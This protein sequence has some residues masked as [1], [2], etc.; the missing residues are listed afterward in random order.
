MKLQN[1]FVLTGLLGLAGLAAQAQQPLVSH[2]NEK[3]DI[4][5][6][7]LLSLD[8]FHAVDLANYVKF[9]PSSML[10]QLS[11]IGVTY[12]N[13]SSSKPSDSFPGL[14][15][16][17]TGG[18]PVSTG[19]YYDN[20]YD[21]KLLPPIT[22]GLGN[23][24]GTNVL[25]D[26]SID[27]DGTILSGG[28]GIN[29]DA[30]P[31]D[32]HTG[33][34]VY[35]HSFLR[36]NTIFEVAKKAGLHTAWSDKHRAY[37]LVN[38][39]TGAGVDDLYTPEVAANI[40]VVGGK[41]VDAT[42]ALAGIGLLSTTKSVKL[43]EA[44]DDLKVKATLNEIDGK[45]HTG[46]KS[47]GTPALFGMNFQAISVGQKL[48]KEPATPA[49]NDPD[50]L[51][52]QSGG[53]L[54][55]QATPGPLLQ[56]ALDHTDASLGMMVAELGKKG[57]LNST[58]IIVT[59]KHGQSPIDPTKRQAA[60]DGAYD[61]ILNGVEPNLIAQKTTDD[62]ALLW[63][64][65]QAV[66]EDAVDALETNQSA[67]HSQQILSGEALKL[68]F[69]DPLHD[70]RVPDIIVLPDFGVIYTGGSKLAEHGGFNETDTHVALLLSNPQLSR[71][72]LKSPVE[73]TQVAPTI[74]QVLNLDPRAL[75]AVRREAT[76]PL[77][78]PGL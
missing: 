19:V 65:D 2:S 14:L 20:S 6:V 77:P 66:T 37:D 18:T 17:I 5:H 29:P 78:L 72:T 50:P 60:D 46:K 11:G 39:P 33:Q 22:F 13:A 62:V 7:L 1:T 70:S 57:L 59:A 58:L 61:T 44:Y 43:T 71:A 27:K 8:G 56:D 42:D 12:T 53:Y 69:P 76:T 32:P 52:S 21:R 38:G 41:A 31:R 23:Y 35:P 34:P 26:E 55:S 73:T 16:L 75:Q 10:G 51:V 40:G 36:V 15:A 24:P 63:L 4:K 64:R 68:I 67:I 28:G 47:V 74:L 49:G 30:L 9:H 25:Y 48:A 54:D 45:D 3:S